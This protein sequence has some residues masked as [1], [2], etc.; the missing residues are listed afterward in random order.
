MSEHRGTNDPRK[1]AIVG[2]TGVGKTAISIEIAHAWPKVALLSCD[3]MAIYRYMD[4]GTAK[5]SADELGGIHYGLIDLVDPDEEFS[6]AQFRQASNWYLGQLSRDEIALFVGGSGLYHTAVFDNLEIPPN[7]PTVRAFLEEQALERG[8]APLWADLVR[9]D[10]V[11]SSRID[12]NNSRRIIR[13]LEVIEITGRRFSEF[14][15][16]V[17]AYPLSSGEIVGIETDLLKA[18]IDLAYRIDRLID[19]GWIEEARWLKENFDL[20]RTALHAIGYLELFRYID[21]ALSLEEAKEA[22]LTRTLQFAKRQR[23]WFGRD[24]RI[25]WFREIKEAQKYI[26]DQIDTL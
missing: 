24:P 26:L 22:T 1:M 10:P 21:G 2:A 23:S 14:G 15:G 4:I 8:L 12:P 16:G 18:R 7:N 19:Y 25:V 17:D 11:A 13:A 9:L 5:P 3:S 20:S 6:I